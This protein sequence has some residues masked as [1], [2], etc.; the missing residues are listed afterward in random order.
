MID[1]LVFAGPN[2]QEAVEHVAELLG[3]RPVAGGRHTGFGTANYLLGLGDRC[4]LEVIGPDP[5]DPDF[6]GQRPFGINGLSAPRLVAWASERADLPAFVAGA[7]DQGVELGEALP[8]SRETTDGHMLRWM[9]T[10]PQVA[11]TG[12]PQ[13]QP[14]FIDWG[15]T[16]HPSVN[17]QG[18]LS[19]EEF[20]LAHPEPAAVQRTL[21]VLDIDLAVAEREELTLEALI[22]TAEGIRVLS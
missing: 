4:Y 6:D 22:E 13:L 1:H 18:Q 7:R 20:H 5:D 3:E 2:L 10:L 19:L 12:E 21:G 9:L 15:E 14:F 16:T 8:M 11:P 17:L